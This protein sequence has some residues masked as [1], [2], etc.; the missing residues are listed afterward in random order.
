[1]KVALIIFLSAA[2]LWSGCTVQKPV[3]LTPK[4]T[5]SKSQ[6]ACVQACSA[7]NSSQGETNRCMDS[8]LTWEKT[9]GTCQNWL[10]QPESQLCVDREEEE[11]STVAQTVV[12]IVFVFALTF[13][14]VA[15]GRCAVADCGN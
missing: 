10:K 15:G 7:E 1:M 6:L 12:I 2:L 4:R 5:P 9:E 11:A 3:H 14:A 8:C 13:A